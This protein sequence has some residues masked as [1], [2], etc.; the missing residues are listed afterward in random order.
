MVSCRSRKTGNCSDYF[1]NRFLQEKDPETFRESF[2][3][4]GSPALC[5]GRGGVAS[6]Q[7]DREAPAWHRRG[8]RFFR[9]WM[10]LPG[11]D[12][13]EDGRALNDIVGRWRVSKSG[14][15]ILGS[16]GR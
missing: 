2:L 11:R 4:P 1:Q 12:G 14:R 9:L 6:T 15:A 7:G 5:V 10:R 3:I 16:S 8:K 13:T